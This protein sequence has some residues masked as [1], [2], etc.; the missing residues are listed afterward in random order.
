MGQP[1]Q[2]SVVIPTLNE[3]ATITACLDQF[4]AWRPGPELI[5]VDGGSTDATLRLLAQHPSQP[6]IIQSPRGR[7]KQLRAGAAEASG[8][9]LLFLHADTLLPPHAGRELFRTLANPQNGGGFF[10]LGIEGVQGLEARMV[11]LHSWWRSFTRTPLGDQAV[12]C[13]R[14]LYELAGGIPD[15]PLLEDYVFASHLRQATHLRPIPLK[16]QASGRR[17]H[18]RFWQQTRHDFTL[19]LRFHLGTSLETLRQ[20]YRDDRPGVEPATASDEPLLDLAP[21][22]VQATPVALQ[23]IAV[24]APHR[25]SID[26]EEPP[27]DLV[28]AAEID[29]LLELSHAPTKVTGEVPPVWEEPEPAL[30]TGEPEPVSGIVFPAPV[31]VDLPT[32][33]TKEAPRQLKPAITSAPPLPPLLGDEPVPALRPSGFLAALS[34]G[35]SKLLFPGDLSG[36]DALEAL[37]AAVLPP[38]SEPTVAPAPEAPLPFASRA[39]QTDLPADFG[40]PETAPVAAGNDPASQPTPPPG[41]ELVDLDAIRLAGLPGPRRPAGAEL[42]DH[43]T[44]AEIAQIRSEL[45][46][47]HH[48]SPE[49]AAAAALYLANVMPESGRAGLQVESPKLPHHPDKP[50]ARVIEVSIQPSDDSPQQRKVSDSE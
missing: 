48:L 6:Y 14:N 23:S 20:E 15:V 25:T 26:F 7:A 8:N 24:P 21:A 47:I 40:Y 41:V 37:P 13:W 46:D 12:F 42:Q 30:A 50:A 39:P 10:A 1:I 43:L 33:P 38:A 5:V 45:T 29:T 27:S 11:A 36:R 35:L 17:F 9:V 44:A 31:A 34:Q 22:A 16:V 18:G 28:T 19:L 3:A 32:A 2:L 49:E 4:A